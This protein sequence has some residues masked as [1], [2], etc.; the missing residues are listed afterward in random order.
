MRLKKQIDQSTGDPTKRA[1][2]KTRYTDGNGESHTT[3]AAATTKQKKANGNAMATCHPSHVN[4]P[5]TSGPLNDVAKDSTRID[6]ATR[7]N[8]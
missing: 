3:N 2:T 8:T 7:T 6:K 5:G 1:S 4:P